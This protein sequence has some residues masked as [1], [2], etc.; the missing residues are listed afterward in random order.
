MRIPTEV[1]AG[2]VQ[3]ASTKM[4]DPNYSAVLVG[5]FVQ[6]QAPAVKYITAHADEL[7]GPEGI[8]NAIFHSA[9]LAV[10]FQRGYNRTVRK[11]SFDELDH[12]AGPDREDTLKVQQPAILDYIEANVEIP[13]MRGVLVLIALAMEWV[14]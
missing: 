1:V 3:E 13:A 9:L 10:C 11:I 4:S 5:G 12:V 7:G 8:V 14:S 6:T 2:V